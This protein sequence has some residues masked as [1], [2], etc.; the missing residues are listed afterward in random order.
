M[1]VIMRLDT[2]GDCGVVGRIAIAHY[3][4]RSGGGQKGLTRSR[5]LRIL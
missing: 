4:G 1:Y 2:G 5:S 3:A